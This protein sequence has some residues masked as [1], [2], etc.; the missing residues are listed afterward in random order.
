MSKTSLK[1]IQFQ[2]PYH[3]DTY[4]LLF[5]WQLS[6]KLNYVDKNGFGKITCS[7]LYSVYH[8]FVSW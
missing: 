4:L 2:L 5:V 6:A 8:V 3:V 7:G 1:C